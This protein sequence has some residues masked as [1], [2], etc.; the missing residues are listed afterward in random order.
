MVRLVT[1]CVHCGRIMGDYEGG[2]GE[3]NQQPLCHPNVIDRPDCYHLVTV[4]HHQ[5]VDCDRC[6]QEPWEPLTPVEQ[7]DALMETLRRLELMI[8]D[9]TP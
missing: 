1:R 3:F 9:I 7:H 6:R 8:Q 4:Y 5:L 2:F